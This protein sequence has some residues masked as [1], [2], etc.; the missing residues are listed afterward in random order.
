MSRAK[1]SLGLG[2][3]RRRNLV[4]IPLI[5]ATLARGRTHRLRPIS[6][7][8]ITVPDRSEAGSRYNAAAELIDAA[9]ARGCGDKV[10]FCDG[11]RSLTYGRLRERTWRMAA[12]FAS[13][14][15]KPENR[16]ALLLHDSV[17]FPVAFWGAVRA[18]MIA[19]PFNTFLSVEQY[20][21]MLAD[22]RAQALVAAPPLARA[23][24]P[25]LDRALHL[26]ALVLAGAS[27]DD[28]AAF[29]S[30]NVHLFDEL[31]A[32]QP[33]QPFT[34]ETV[35]DEVAFWLYT[36][37]STGAPKAVKHI[38]ASPMATARLFGQGVLG[39]GGDD[40]IF[41]AA[42]LFFAYGLGN[43]MTFPLSAG[44]TAVLLH[45]RPTPERV[46]AV[47]R[48]HRPTV[49]FGVP[50]LYAALLAHPELRAG[51]GSDR[52]R[53][54]VSA[55]EALPA[56]LG[57]RWRETVGVDILDGIGSTEM[58]QTFVSNRPGD[59][60]YGSTG[61]PVPGYDVKI[62]DEHDVEIGEGE[63][64]ELLVRGPSAGEG[65]WNQRAKSRITFQGEWTRTGDRF[66]RDRD[67]YYHYCGR[68]DDMFKV[69][70][71]WVS[72]FDV[73]AALVSHEAVREAAVIG[74]QDA[75][76]L[77]K[78]KAFIVLRDGYAADERLFAALRAHVKASAGTWK[79][80]RW[81][82]VCTDLPRTP[83]GKIQRF[84]L[85]DQESGISDQAS[86]RSQS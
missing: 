30:R 27:T 25:I 5:C 80:P 75:D 66:Q 79:H 70:G 85:R 18:G 49:F 20:A 16:I 50:S 83:T 14:G 60:R 19:V 43:A 53:L 22:S 44:A 56:R 69:S 46:F 2:A 76:G 32:R 36:S 71:M 33:A 84:M 82:E 62:V 11:E 65:Y 40:V 52:L 61:K 38:H 6:R 13:L 86:G 64:G 73:E 57:E 15:L 51:M 35:A 17:D 24:A 10:A 59:L 7:R 78:P 41:S 58:L 29:A 45:D 12:A 34:A 63:T 1:P 23:L 54:C 8:E 47:M 39:I 81:V 72:P 28:K 48:E 42:K 77:I 26:R 74:K 9:I 68:S 55:G 4:A 21:Y 67:G 37:G 3:C 31:L